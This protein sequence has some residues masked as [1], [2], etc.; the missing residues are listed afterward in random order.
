[1]GRGKRYMDRL[2]ILGGTFNPIHVAHLSI[3]EQVGEACGLG[4]VLF[5][6]AHIPPHK[7]SPDIA[8]AEDRYR[9]TVLATE[10]NPRFEVSRIEVDRS[11]T[12]FTKDTLRELLKKYPGRELFYI[13]GSD[14]VAELPTWREPDVVVKLAKLLVVNRPG[15]ELERLDERFRKNV[16]VV[17]VSA[18]DVSSTEIRE[19]IRK[20]LSIGHLVPPKVERYIKENG[21]YQV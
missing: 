15:S 5:V 12:S 7:D 1:M 2:G 8:P 13:I 9:M 14:A 19:R 3:A 21:L 18:S 17:N 11:G 6:P 10:S 20:G 4:K 16:E